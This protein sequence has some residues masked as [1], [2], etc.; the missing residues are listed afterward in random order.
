MLA[1]LLLAAALGSVGAT[2]GG[3]ALQ[4]DWPAFLARS[5]LLWAWNTTSGTQPE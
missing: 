2:A 4:V 3:V 5:D 1:A